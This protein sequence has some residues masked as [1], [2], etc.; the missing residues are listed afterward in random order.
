MCRKM[1]PKLSI[2]T[3]NR[4]NAEGLRKTIESVVTQTGLKDDEL[5]YIIIDG[6]STDHS[7]EVIKEFVNHPEYG[8][9]I[10]YWVSEPDT[11]I[12][13]AMNKGIK[14]ATGTLVGII[15]SGDWLLENT[16]SVIFDTHRKH[17]ESILYGCIK[18]FE[19]NVFIDIRGENNT[20][21]PSKMISHPATFV[22]M[23]VYKQ[24]G[25]YDEKLKIAADY[26]LFLRI[27]FKN[28]S[29]F[30]LDLIVTNFDYSGISSTS[31]LVGLETE[32]V[33]KRYNLYKK[34]S[35][36]ERLKHFLKRFF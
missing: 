32:L 20:V 24:I 1:T 14:K 15:N 28:Y 7:V 2:I 13:N 5:E 29:F 17:I 18:V 30:F 36:K 3:I 11:G 33:K 16:L 34:P 26:D 8:K 4:N 22:P 19:N 21:L 31:N 10:S 12:Y 6:A 25:Y 9:Y 27:Y 23:N 35:T